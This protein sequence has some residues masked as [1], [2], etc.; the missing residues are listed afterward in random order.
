LL[1]VIEEL[2]SLRENEPYLKEKTV[3]ELQSRSKEAIQKM[4]LGDFTSSLEKYL[5]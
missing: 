3:R 5:G 1:K 4:I 2:A